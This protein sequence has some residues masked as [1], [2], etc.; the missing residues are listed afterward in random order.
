MQN[1]RYSKLIILGLCSLPACNVLAETHPN[2]QA[3]IPK[4]WT[5]FQKVEGD[6]NKDGQKDIA[7]IIEEKNPKNIVKNDALG[8]E[9]LD[10]NPR[11]LLILFKDQQSYRL[12]GSNDTIPSA[13]DAD[14]P[15]LADPLAEFDPLEIKNGVLQVAFHYWY[16][17]GSWYVNNNTYSFRYE[18]T[19]QPNKAS[20]KLIGFDSTDFHRASGDS[21][22]YSVNFLTGKTKSTSGANEFAEQ[23]Q[24]IKTTWS[25]LKQRYDLSLSQINFKENN[26]FE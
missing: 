13:N 19:P 6:L 8:S 10:L 18:N 23:K 24:K 22:T 17:C 12:V 5:L 2:I 14:A 25:K 16:S 20:F 9:E 11:K 21:S 3:F 26:D 1:K 4:G 15:C 7:M